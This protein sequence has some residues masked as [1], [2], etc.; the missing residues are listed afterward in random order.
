MPFSILVVWLIS[1]GLIKQW[2]HEVSTTKSWFAR[3]KKLNWKNRENYEN[4]TTGTCLLWKLSKK[5]SGEL[6]RIVYFKNAQQKCSTLFTF[7]NDLEKIY[8][9]TGKR[10]N[11]LKPLAKKFLVLNFSGKVI[12]LELRLVKAY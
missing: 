11:A 9:D 5:N 8:V 2:T 1:L 10:S 7:H 3:R 4:H 6:E 12:C